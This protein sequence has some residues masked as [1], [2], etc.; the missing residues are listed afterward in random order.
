MDLGY[1]LGILALTLSILVAIYTLLE[2]KEAKAG[3][4]A[5]LK[6][7]MEINNE[8]LSEIKGCIRNLE[9]SVCH[10]GER[11]TVTEQSIKNTQQNLENL[12][13]RFESK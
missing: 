1:I 7:K 8:T 11:L 12:N 10:Y 3:I 6:T 4:L 13:G 9:E 2:K 5:E